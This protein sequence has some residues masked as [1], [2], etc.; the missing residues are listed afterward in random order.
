MKKQPDQQ[1]FA[2]I[3]ILLVLLFATLATCAYMMVQRSQKEENEVQLSRASV[4]PSDLSGLISKEKLAELVLAEN[5]VAVV[6]NVEL[7]Q[8][9][10]GTV[11]KVVLSDGSV[12]RFDATT[13][14]KSGD[15]SS[16][17]NKNEDSDDS[18]DS[19]DHQEED[20]EDDGDVSG[21]DSSSDHDDSDDDSS[22]GSDNDSD[23]D[24]SGSN[25]GS[26]SN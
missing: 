21:S 26:G 10:S 20:T 3:S 1:G 5:P 6:A 4:L 23:D 12:L 8:E 13:R 7:E 18:K 14:Q 22:H 25:S 2:F 24:N 17:D 15:D 11:Y 16:D 9:D 19:E